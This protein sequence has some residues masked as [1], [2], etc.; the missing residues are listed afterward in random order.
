MDSYL[1][2][3]SK[4]M[5]IMSLSLI[6]PRARNTINS[7]IGLRTFGILTTIFLLEY[8]VD[9]VSIFTDNVLIGLDTFSETER[10]SAE[11]KYFSSFTS[12]IYNILSANFSCG[13]TVFSF[14]S[15]IKYPPISFLHSPMEYRISRSKPFRIQK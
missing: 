4:H 15:I 7:G 10:I 6:I 14:P 13:I 3:S 8:L 12:R 11:Y 9:G 5:V 1:S 2:K